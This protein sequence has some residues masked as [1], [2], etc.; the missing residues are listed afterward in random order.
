MPLSILKPSLEK[1]CGLLL[2]ALS[3]AVAAEEWIYK[4]RPGDNLWNLTERHLKSMDYAQGLQQI[5]NIRNPYV[6]PPGTH[7]RIPIAWVK[8]LDEVSAQVI[9]V[10]G[11]VMLQRGSQQSMP[12][13][14]G[15]QL[16]AGDEIRSAE[17]AFVTIEFADKSLL[18]VQENTQ[19][20][21]EN[22]RILGDQGLFD[23][24]IDLREGRTESSVPSKS[25]KGIRFRIK[26]PPAITSVRGTDFRVGA[27]EGK[28][29]TSS[30]VL[31]GMVEIEGGKKQVKVPAGFGAVTAQDKPPMSPV[32]LLPP[33]DLSETNHYYQKLPLVI[34]FNALSGAQAYRAQIAIDRN[35]R[36][37]WSEFT[38]ASLPFR[39][40]NIPDGDYWLRVRGIDRLQIEGMD[41]AIPFSLNAR[42]EAPFIIAPLPSG[43]TAPEKQ[44]FKWAIQ[45][46]ASHYAFMISRN[47][48]FTQ[49]VYFDP[50]VKDNGV[51]LTESLAPGYYFWRIFSVSA[52]EGAGPFSDTMPFRVPYPSPSLEEPKLDENEM[53]F[54]W[55]ATAEGQSFDFQFA[56]DKEFADILH[57]ETTAASQIVI[58][59]PASGTYYLRIKAIESD[60]FQGPW[61]ATQMIEVPRGI[62]YWFMLL[63]LLPLLVL[64]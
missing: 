17:D 4:V 33:P 26:T 30:E 36:N 31:T 6:I 37:L 10:H 58:P 28:S 38:T 27:T 44:E 47:A 52:S 15:M 3:V 53:T 7:L 41:A 39:D 25:E 11:T 57:E 32:K 12:I 55:S 20:R 18:R 60:G 45:S 14:M 21:L 62:S 56:R 24:L 50:E 61:G 54:A 5:N 13:E 29:V 43:M 2:M 49:L 42:P 34:Q 59:K 19:L 46:E 1:C 16:L 51:T 40:G 64:L 63:M 48:D 8:M 35:F 22:M 23:T 9:S